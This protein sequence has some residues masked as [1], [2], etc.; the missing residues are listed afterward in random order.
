MYL[1]NGD[2]TVTIVAK[3]SAQKPQATEIVRDLPTTFE[4]E[5]CLSKK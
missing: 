5:V 4:A 1:A 2:E 3:N